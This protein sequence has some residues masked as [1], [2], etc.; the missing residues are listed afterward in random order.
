VSR[1]RLDDGE[2]EPVSVVVADALAADPLEGLEQ[3][4]DIPGRDDLFVAARSRA[5]WQGA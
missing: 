4:L 2:S 3:P 5:G 1:T